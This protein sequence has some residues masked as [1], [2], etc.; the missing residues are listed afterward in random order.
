[1]LNSKKYDFINIYILSERWRVV[2]LQRDNNCSLILSEVYDGPGVKSSQLSLGQVSTGFIVLLKI[3]QNIMEY[4]C[5]NGFLVQYRSYHVLANSHTMEQC[6]SEREGPGYLELIWSPSKLPLRHNRRCIWQSGDVKR[7]GLTVK[8]FNFIGPD[9][10]LDNEEC[11]FGG[12]F[13][14][15][16]SG[17]SYKN[18]WSSC[19]NYNQLRDIPIFITQAKILVTTVEFTQYSEIVQF[20]GIIRKEHG[21]TFSIHEHNASNGK[22]LIDIQ[23]FPMNYTFHQFWPKLK[24]GSSW[25][26]FAGYTS[27]IYEPTAYIQSLA[28]KTQSYELTFGSMRSI[29][30]VITFV[31]SKCN[32]PPFGC[33]CASFSVRFGPK[34]TSYYIPEANQQKDFRTVD[35]LSSQFLSSVTSLSVNQSKCHPNKK[36]IWMLK[37]SF[38]YNSNVIAKKQVPVELVDDDVYS[39]LVN[40]A[41]NKARKPIWVLFQLLLY[42]SDVNHPKFLTELHVKEMHCEWTTMMKSLEVEFIKPGSGKA[43]VYEASIAGSGNRIVHLKSLT[44]HPCNVIIRFAEVHHLCANEGVLLIEARK[45]IQTQDIARTSQIGFKQTNITFIA[46]R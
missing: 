34:I 17:K 2:S 46:Q 42:E 9:I 6:I 12:L 35:L 21:L 10:L 36:S 41:D 3:Q 31:S 44:C 29:S 25:D 5:L 24:V 18:A 11:L 39:L 33:L 45:F 1:M 27:Y 19:K 28:D 8:S 40:I 38:R 7:S 23:N 26:Q 4:K 20:E 30:A 32:I 15:I 37:L 13:I 16:R 22:Y 14:Y 43:V